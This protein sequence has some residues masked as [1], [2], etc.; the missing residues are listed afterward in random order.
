[1]ISTMQPLTQASAASELGFALKVAEARKLA[2][3]NAKCRNIRVLF[4]P[5]V[6]ETLGGWSLDSIALIS[7][8]GKLVGERLGTPPVKHLFQHL[9]IILSSGEGM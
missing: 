9:F 4:L 5:V 1:M 8:I 6:V 7:R 2:T 3:H